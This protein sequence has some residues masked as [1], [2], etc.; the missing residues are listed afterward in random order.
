MEDLKDSLQD[1]TGK[2]YT[3]DAGY[4]IERSETLQQPGVTPKDIYK[5]SKLVKLAKVSYK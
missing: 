2:E 3:A 1:R 5:N 4:E